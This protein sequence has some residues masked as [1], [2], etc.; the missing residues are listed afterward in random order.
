M[1]DRYARIHALAVQGLRQREIARIVG[2]S[3]ATVNAVLRRPADHPG[4]RLVPN[5]V[6]FRPQ[7]WMEDAACIGVPERVFF[8]GRNRAEAWVLARQTC[9]RCG[10]L[11]R[12]RPYAIELLTHGFAAG[13]TADERREYRRHATAE[14]VPIERAG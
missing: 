1:A 2:C 9:A 10:V 6:Q 12:C 8:P 7:S 3:Q 5:P 4:G 14:A 13:M 11:D